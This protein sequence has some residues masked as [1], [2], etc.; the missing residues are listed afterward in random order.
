MINGLMQYLNSSA[1][2]LDVVF[3]LIGFGLGM[4]GMDWLM[5][6]RRR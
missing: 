6:R 1:T 4:K 3:I 2:I 5:G